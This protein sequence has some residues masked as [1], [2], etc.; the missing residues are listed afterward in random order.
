M[1]EYTAFTDFAKQFGIQAAFFLAIV[2]GLWKAAK[3]L[4]RVLFSEER[5]SKGDYRGHVLRMIDAHIGLVKKVGAE[6][7]QQTELLK[8]VHEEVVSA[9]KKIDC[10]PRAG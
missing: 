7:E 8:Q 10:P 2:V 3:F 6:V 5:D 9:A 4:G 1:N